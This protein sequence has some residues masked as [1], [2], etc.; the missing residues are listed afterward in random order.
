MSYLY[1]G[2]N[3]SKQLYSELSIVKL[4]QRIKKAPHSGSMMQVPYLPYEEGVVMK[5]W[6]VNNDID[7]VDFNGN[8]AN[9][10]EIQNVFL[11]GC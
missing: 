4:T 11:L 5:N 8:P 1:E 2:N 6:I 9:P 10:T 3:T 7:T